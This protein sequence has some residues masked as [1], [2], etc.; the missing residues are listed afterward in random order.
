MKK[1]RVLVLA[2]LEIGTWYPWHLRSEQFSYPR[3]Y[4]TCSCQLLLDAWV[5]WWLMIAIVLIHNS[6]K[7]RQKFIKSK[8]V[9]RDW[10]FK[11]L[12]HFIRE[13]I[14]LYIAANWKFYPFSVS[15]SIHS[16]ACT[17]YWLMHSTKIGTS[18]VFTIMYQLEENVQSIQH[19]TMMAFSIHTRIYY[20]SIN[21]INSFNWKISQGTSAIIHPNSQK[22]EKNRR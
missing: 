21:S 5:Q 4:S 22:K 16:N 9:T 6:Y 11:L 17:V 10:K 1:S 12:G 2:S 20:C 15:N 8:K 7:L 3:T 18:T 13:S 14:I 19:T